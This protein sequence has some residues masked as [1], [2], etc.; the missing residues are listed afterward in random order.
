MEFFNWKNRLEISRYYSLLWI[1]IPA[2]HQD[3][4]SRWCVCLCVYVALPWA[5]ASVCAVCQ[6]VFVC[7]S[8]IFKWACHVFL[9]IGGPA[10]VYDAVWK[11]RGNDF[12]FP[13]HSVE[14]LA[15]YEMTAIIKL[16]QS[17]RQA[18]LSPWKHTHIHALIHKH[19]HSQAFTVAD[20]VKA[21]HTELTRLAAVTGLDL[22][23][24][25]EES[26]ISTRLQIPDVFLL[27]TTELWYSAQTWL[28]P[29]RLLRSGSG[30]IL[31]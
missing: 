24:L 1:S 28:D 12:F 21:E 18:L 16:T 13:S 29:T 26:G 10:K 2:Y 23:A 17:E 25:E 3:E 6:H 30:S 31:S 14:A 5:R 27:V 8:H 9:S 19:T 22:L 20:R 4:P 7:V 15:W 11:E